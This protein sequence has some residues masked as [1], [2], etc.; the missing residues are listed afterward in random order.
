MRVVAMRVVAVLLASLL[1]FH[2][3]FFIEHYTYSMNPST[4]TETRRYDEIAYNST[5]NM[6]VIVGTEQKLDAGMMR[7]IQ[8]AGAK[9][10]TKSL[11]SADAMKS[12]GVVYYYHTPS[13]GE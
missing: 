13:T 11:Q 1:F 8:R 7:G 5:S 12:C 2:C 3:L 9:S 6:S 10:L 4:D